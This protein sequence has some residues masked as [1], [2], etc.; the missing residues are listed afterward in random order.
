MAQVW[1]NICTVAELS[2]FS[3]CAGDV[4]ALSSYA[5]SH[6]QTMCNGSLSNVSSLY[7][8]WEC[9]LDTNLAITIYFL[10]SATL[11]AFYLHQSLYAIKKGVKVNKT[12]N[13]YFFG[14]FS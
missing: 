5:I 10:K 11:L 6:I 1:A 4:H 8:I 2:I 14:L 13:G 12:V 3:R 7:I 9:E